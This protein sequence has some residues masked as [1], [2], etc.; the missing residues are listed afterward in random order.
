MPR[1]RNV[2]RKKNSHIPSIELSYACCLEF[3]FYVRLLAENFHCANNEIK[4]SMS[5]H[6]KILISWVS[7]D[8]VESEEEIQNM[9]TVRFCREHNVVIN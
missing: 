4:E 8:S 6:E 9:F 7:P 2:S 5:D 3:Y 1:H